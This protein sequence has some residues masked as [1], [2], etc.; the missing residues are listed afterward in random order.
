MWE[1]TLTYQGLVLYSERWSPHVMGPEW[2]AHVWRAAGAAL[3]RHVAEL[4]AKDDRRS[5]EGQYRLLVSTPWGAVLS[6]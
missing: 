1:V 2:F 3:A 4:A 6:G 5:L